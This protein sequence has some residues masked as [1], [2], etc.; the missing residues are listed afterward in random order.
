MTKIN[1]EVDVDWQEGEYLTEEELAKIIITR[2]RLGRLYV[3]DHSGRIARMK[4]I[5][6]IRD[7]AVQGK[8]LNI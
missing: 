2:V 4:S 7:A 1:L 8:L 3:F 6:Y 5:Y